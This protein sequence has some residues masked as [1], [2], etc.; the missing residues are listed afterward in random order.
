MNLILIILGAAIFINGVFLCIYSN[1]DLG[2][3]LTLLLGAFFFLW[4]VYRDKIKEITKKGIL[5]YIKCVVLALLTAELL[6]VSFI[7]GFGAIDNATYKEDAVIVLGAAVRG[8]RV[9]LPLQ[10]RLDSAAE[11]YEK[12][13][14]A[15]IIVTG[16]KGLQEDITEAHAMERY[17]VSKGVPS[18]NIIKEENATSTEEN[19]A[20]SKEIADSIF[21]EGYSVCVITNDFHIY[22]GVSMAENAG[23]ANVTHKGADLQWYNLCSCYLRESLAVLKLWIAG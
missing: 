2:N 3:M 20:F 1:F 9:T 6:L 7:A 14:D 12:N 4:G 18:E 23:F 10:Y 13:P 5:K 21:N 17:L 8:E 16:G 19:M 11:Y 15:K 22:R